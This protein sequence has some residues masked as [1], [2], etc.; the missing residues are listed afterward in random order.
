MCKNGKFHHGLASESTP[1]LEFAT[2]I[3]VSIWMHFVFYVTRGRQRRVQ[4][5]KTKKIFARA[6]IAISA[7][8]YAPLYAPHFLRLCANGTVNPNFC[9]IVW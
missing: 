9:L 5:R 7:A 8:F 6:R 2:F 3:L 1:H 4:L